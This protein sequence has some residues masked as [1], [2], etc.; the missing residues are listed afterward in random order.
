MELRKVDLSNLWELLALKVLPEQAEF[1]APNDGSILEAYATI[2]S[3]YVAQPF[4]I[5][6]NQKPVGFVMFG[7]GSLGDSDDPP[8]AEENYCLWRFM[9][10]QAYQ[11]QGLGKQALALCIDYLR[12]F[13]CGPAEYCWLSYEPENQRAKALYEKAGFA[14]NGEMCGEEIVS[15]L[16]L[17]TAEVLNSGKEQNYVNQ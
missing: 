9:I 2:A 12:T 11:G 3:G 1:V 7:Y 13:P 8:V 15:V 17:K 4:G 6:V 5:Y 14:E 16:K 10:D